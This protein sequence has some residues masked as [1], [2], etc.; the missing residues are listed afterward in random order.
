MSGAG[1]EKK[2]IADSGAK[3]DAPRR[4][5]AF[6]AGAPIYRIGA[7]GLAWRVERGSVRLD[8]DGHSSEA[9]FASLSLPGD[10]IGSESMLFGS[11]AFSA[12]ALTHC[13]LSPWPEGAPAAEGN[14]LLRSLAASQRRAAE[15]VALRGGEAL[16]RVTGL[17][18][19]MAG[20]VSEDC[21]ANVVLPT[22]KDIADITALRLETVSRIIKHLER[23]G[24]LH[25]VRVEGVH[26]TRSFAVNFN[27]FAG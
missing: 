17:I 21:T 3:P 24:M 14:S 6:A 12:S 9:C 13:E 15:L 16:K 11:Y 23:S 8:A 19:I 1:Q 7:P 5:L 18:R 25:P 26:A 2:A 4:S 10:I 20:A 22:R 27:Q